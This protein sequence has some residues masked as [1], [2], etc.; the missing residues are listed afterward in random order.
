MRRFIALFFALSV[1]I[2]IGF[3][4]KAQ[5][6]NDEVLLTIGGKPVTAGEF[7]SVYKKNDLKKGEPIDAKKLEDYLNLYI[8][9]KL[10]V[11]EAEELGFDTVSTFITE[12][13]GYRDQLAKPYFTDEATI[14][15]L[16][17][18]A[19]E[20]EKSDLRTRHIF[21][22]LASDASPKDTLEAWHKISKVRERLLN[23]E[24]FEKL[25]AE[26]SEDPSARDREA[27]QQHPFLKGNY[28]DLGYFTVF[29]YVYSFESGAYK[30]EPG[31][32]SPIIRTEYGYHLIKVTAKNEALGKVTAAHIFMNIPKNASHD[33][34]LRVYQRIDSVYTRLKNGA[35]WEDM[36]KQYSDDKGSALKGGALPKFG[37]NRMVPE[38]IDALYKMANDGDISTPIQTQYGWHIIRLIERKRPGTFE[39]EK[40]DLKQKVLKD[41]RSDLAKQAVI[42]MIK[43]ESNFVE[44]PD[45]VKDFYTVITDSIFSGKWD[46]TLAKNLT[47]PMFQI[48]TQ[49]YNQKDFTAWL[50]KNQRKTEKQKIPYFVDRAYKDFVN[51]NLI[52]YENTR[53]ESKYPDFRN[54][55]SEYR[56]GI[57]LFDLTDQKVWSK[58]V[59]DTTGLKNFYENNK[60]SYMWEQRLDASIYTIS[61]QKM[62]QKV[63]NFI[64]SGLTDDALL[65]EINV[66][67]AKILKIESGKYSRKENKYIDMI[68]WAP[69]LSSELPVPPGAV[70]VFVRKVLPPEVKTLNEARGLIT[71]D[72]QNYLEKIWV[73]YLRTK[74][75]VTVNKAVL[76]QIK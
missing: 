23:G 68:T 44:M 41:G 17:R 45:A 69:G 28:G 56:D 8:N 43:K 35:K 27:N 13:K 49:R 24:A 52:R 1:V 53:L 40:A 63:R 75:K 3:P 47:K 76:S 15:R 14:D 67:T 33:D 36:V 59:K 32:V 6:K 54:L 20:R 61:D 64:I 39:E 26:V 16:V 71:N 74:Y 72:Y 60:A 51:E 30:T 65:K 34:S 55:M 11:R 66:D 25:A 37:V 50:G 19:Y 5:V 22:K 73:E 12:L 4:L 10:K 46:V 7:M 58:A 2:G 9:F 31:K 42:N 48:S 29:D 62:A 21:V 18:E 70:L 57:L 38:F